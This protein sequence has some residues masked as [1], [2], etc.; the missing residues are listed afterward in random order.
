MPKIYLHIGMNKTGSSVIQSYFHSNRTRLESMGVLWP[1]TGLGS[2]NS[3]AGYHYSLSAALG[4]GPRRD[5]AFSPEELQDLRRRLDGEIAKSEPETVIMSSEFF[6]LNR[7]MD[8]VRRFFDGIDLNI[9]VYLR[10][11]DVWW[12]S[13]YMQ[14]VKTTARPPWNRSFKGY[15]EFQNKKR[16]QHLNFAPFLK[17]WADAFGHD[18]IHVRPFEEGQ[19]NPDLVSHFLGVVGRPDV[20]DNIPPPKIRINEALAPRSLS[21]IDMV[22]RSDIDQTLKNCIIRI[23]ATEDRGDDGTELVPIV[24]QRQLVEENINEYEWVAR[25]F[26]NRPD[27][28]L[29]YAPLPAKAEG[30]DDITLPPPK[31]VEFFARH[32]QSSRG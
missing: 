7:S 31:I 18:R 12:R 30:S 11:H 9:I 27:G 15:Y 5:A 23:I 24:M 4:F 25:G 1:M 2:E 32:F 22:Q 14:A 8:L 6:V 16:N 17:I 20:I 13:L 26:L 10:R 19:N 3:G 28:Q 29:F 21:L